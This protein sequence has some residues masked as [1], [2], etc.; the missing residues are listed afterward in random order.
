MKGLRRLLVRLIASLALGR[1]E[2]RLNHEVEEQTAD[3]LKAGLPLQEAR[4]PFFEQLSK[5]FGTHFV[6]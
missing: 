3:D 1:D 2:R 4:L 6:D 5:T